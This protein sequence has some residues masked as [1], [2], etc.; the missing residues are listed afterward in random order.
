MIVNAAMSP[1]ENV[2][3]IQALTSRIGTLGQSVDFWNTWMVW[4][5]VFAAIAAIAVVVATRIALTRAKQLAYVQAELTQAKDRQLRLDLKDKDEKIAEANLRAA[6][7]EDK[8]EEER[9]ARVRIEEKL[10]GWRLEAAAQQRIVNHL[11]PY[12]GT[13]FDLGVNPNERVFMETVDSIL[14]SSGWDRHMPKPDNPLV[15]ILMDGK[16]R[17]NYV[18]GISV[19]VSQSSMRTFGPAMEALVAALNKEGIP[20]KGYGSLS[21]PD[22]SAIHI[23][24]GSK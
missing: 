14:I 10:A 17:V 16:A 12:K 22:A 19:E 11:K 4:A 23:L 7:A 24:I 1:G 6:S 13:P 9:L 20:A 21:E 5:L 15:S 2:S 18:S 8:A 3:E